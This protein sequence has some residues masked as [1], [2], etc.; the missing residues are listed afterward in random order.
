MMKKSIQNSGILQDNQQ[1]FLALEENSNI[2][3]YNSFGILTEKQNLWTPEAQ[4]SIFLTAV[5]VSAPLPVSIILSDNDNDFLTIRITEPLSSMSQRF[6][7]PYK[8]GTNNSIMVSTSDENMECNTFGAANATQAAFNGRS[9][10]SNINNAIGLHNGSLAILNSA[11]LNQSSGRI[12]L[13]YTMLPSEYE[14][15]EIK[16]VIIKYYCRLSLTLAVGV[17]SMILYWRPNSQGN[18]IQLQRIDLSL[19]GTVNYLTTPIEYD[20]TDTVLGAS[21]PWEVI[22]GLQTSFVGIHTGLGLGN[23]VQ[24]DAI[25]IEIC[26]TGK[27]QITLFGYES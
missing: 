9:D 26:M 16:Q 12:I 24:L 27:N 14:F 23:V 18:W 13:G 21:N 4:K 6:P 19:I 5:Q 25:E 17:S 20:I 11:L 1:P 22:N 15:L 8:L 10:F 2:V 3:K 7:S